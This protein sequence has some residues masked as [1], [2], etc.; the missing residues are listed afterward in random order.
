MFSTIFTLY[1]KPDGVLCIFYLDNGWCF[2]IKYGNTFSHKQGVLTK[3]AHQISILVCAKIGEASSVQA[4]KFDRNWLPH[5]RF[6]ES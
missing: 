3:Q 1:P 2:Y 4:A 6:S 5:Q